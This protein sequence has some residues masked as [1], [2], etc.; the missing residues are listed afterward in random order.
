LHPT[1]RRSITTHS[2]AVASR[3]QNPQSGLLAAHLLLIEGRVLSARGKLEEAITALRKGY[4]LSMSRKS[5]LGFPWGDIAGLLAGLYERTG[6]MAEAAW[7]DHHIQR[8]ASEVKYS[9]AAVRLAKSYASH[10]EVLPHCKLLIEDLERRPLF[11]RLVLMLP[12]I[13][14][15][16]EQLKSATSPGR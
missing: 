11:K 6:Q 10:G 3:S 16:L 5:L 13:D 1:S 12:A 14:D 7:C 4:F 2:P 9:G 15:I 8:Y